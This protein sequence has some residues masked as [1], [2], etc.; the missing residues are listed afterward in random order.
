[1]R[2]AAVRS[3]DLVWVW[4]YKA[5]GR[6]YRRW[7]ARVEEAGPERIVTWT[8]PD[9]RV[10]QVLP[11]SATGELAWR[12]FTQ[13]RGIRSYFWPGQPRTLLEV[14][15][16]DGSLYELYADVCGPVTVVEGAVHY[17]D[18][19][20]DVSQM[21]GEVPRIVD[22]DEFAEAAVTYGY[23]EAFQREC[24]EMAE[25]LL[26]FVAAWVPKMNSTRIDADKT[27]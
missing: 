18:H 16:P 17:T 14:Y 13:P 11:G 19:E 25:A 3:G 4:V 24:Y 21:A 5:D 1:M 8:S 10:Y 9:N 2:A 27:D 6:P 15:N 22:Q 23:S 20:L 12:E 26:A 7:Q